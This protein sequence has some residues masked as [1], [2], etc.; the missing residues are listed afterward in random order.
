[1]GRFQGWFPKT[2]ESPASVDPGILPGHPHLC[3]AIFKKAFA[4]LKPGMMLV[5]ENFQLIPED[6]RAQEILRLPVNEIPPGNHLD[7]IGRKVCCRLLGL[8]AQGLSLYRRFEKRLKAE[9]GIEPYSRNRAVRDRL[10]G[11]SR[12]N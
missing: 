11:G 5:L 4:Q 9:L 10:P 3:P 8:R 7:L 2:K 6:S 1:M 12:M